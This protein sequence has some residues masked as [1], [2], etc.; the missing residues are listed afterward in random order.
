MAFHEAAHRDVSWHRAQ[1]GLPLDEDGQ[2][3]EMKLIAPTGVLLVLSGNQVR[4]LWTDGRMGAL[5]GADLA[6][7]HLHRA[8]LAPERFVVPALEGGAAQD[9]PLAVDRMVPFFSGQFLELK[10]QLAARGRRSQKR[11]DDAE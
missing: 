8:V 4:Q 10:L 5:I 7:E 11:S 6:L 3:V 1:F 9:D 2:V